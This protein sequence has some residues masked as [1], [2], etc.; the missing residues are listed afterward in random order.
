MDGLKV[1]F[2]CLS[3]IYILSPIDA[4][5]G[6]LIDD[7]IAVILMAIIYGKMKASHPDSD[8]ERFLSR[9]DDISD[10]DEQ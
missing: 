4:A 6:L 8:E 3:V 1:L 5:P 7:V 9:T 10:T 2:I